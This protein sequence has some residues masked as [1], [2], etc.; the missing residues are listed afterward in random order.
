[1]KNNIMS[2]GVLYINSTKTS[3][4]GTKRVYYIALSAYGTTETLL[5]AKVEV[6]FRREVG[7]SFE[8]KEEIR[9]VTKLLTQVGER[10][11]FQGEFDDFGELIIDYKSIKSALQGHSSANIYGNIEVYSYE[12]HNDLFDV[13]IKSKNFSS[14]GITFLARCK[15]NTAEAKEKLKRAFGLVNLY[16]EGEIK[17]HHISIQRIKALK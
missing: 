13:Q 17:N 10:I 3:Y 5:K 9:R 1:M 11:S 6:P 4:I 14:N 16:I 7:V 8:R 2:S 12:E 15:A